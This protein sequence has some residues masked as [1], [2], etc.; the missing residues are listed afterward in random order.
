[1][2][3]SGGCLPLA[4]ASRGVDCVVMCALSFDDG[5]VFTED[6][7]HRKGIVQNGGPTVNAKVTYGSAIAQVLTPK[8]AKTLQDYADYIVTFYVPRHF[9]V[10]E[11]N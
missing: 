2:R 9:R 1:M 7:L 11:K 3:P 6:I 5:M 4:A 8:H 10:C